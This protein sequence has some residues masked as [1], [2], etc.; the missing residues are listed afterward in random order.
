MHTHTIRTKFTFGD[1]VRFDSV[2]TRSG[3][4]TV[5][6]IVFGIYDGRTQ[7]YYMLELK[8]GDIQGGIT[9]D[10]MT[11]VEDDTSSDTPTTLS[12]PRVP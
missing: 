2:M 1:R 9:E 11:L 12:S 6:E 5:L 10:E 7:I 8:S 4:G 3:V